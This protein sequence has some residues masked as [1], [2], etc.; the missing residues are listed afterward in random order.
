MREEIIKWRKFRY[1]WPKIGTSILIAHNDSD[2]GMCV[3][4][5]DFDER[6]KTAMEDDYESYFENGHKDHSLFYDFCASGEYSYKIARI[7]SK[8]M[9]WCYP[10]DI[11]LPNLR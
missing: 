6:I 1:E 4:I 7:I 2:E 11:C 9:Y 3:A 5:V 10:N 8:D